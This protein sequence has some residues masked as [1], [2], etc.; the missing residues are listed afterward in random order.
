M[1]PRCREI[2]TFKTFKTFILSIGSLENSECPKLLSNITGRGWF[3][4]S[5]NFIPISYPFT[6]FVYP[7]VR[8][9]SFHVK[10]E[11]VMQLFLIVGSKLKP[12]CHSVF[13][14]HSHFSIPQKPVLSADRN[15]AGA[16]IPSET[17]CLGRLVLGGREKH[18][19]SYVPPVICTI[20]WWKTI[21]DHN[22]S[23]RV[24]CY[25]I[26]GV[27]V[28]LHP[29]ESWCFSWRDPVSY[30]IFPV[31]FGLCLARPPCFQ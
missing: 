25:C 11:C 22:W 5:Y 3:H 12:T 10:A 21:E 24:I 18:M 30:G 26:W 1:I 8:G 27:K 7:M 29:N 17:C 2:K 16:P 19:L 15:F 4:Y 31:I 6:Q 9:F 14:G 28:G 13:L 20:L 23:G